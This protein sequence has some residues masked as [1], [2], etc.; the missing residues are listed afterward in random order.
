[1]NRIMKPA[2]VKA[3][4]FPKP[5]SNGEFPIFLRIYKNR[6]SSYVS[7]GY[8]IPA[9]AWNEEEDEVWESMPSLTAKMKAT[10]G[11]EEQ[12]AFKEMQK[13]IILLPNAKKINSDI[14]AKV[15]ELEAI[16]NR[17]L[18]N[19]EDITSSI[20][21]DKADRK[22]LAELSRKD[23][24]SYI[25]EVI[26]KKFAGKQIRT[27]EKYEVLK[28]K[29]KA[30]RKDKPLPIEELTTSFLKGFQAYLKEEGSH[31]NYIHVNLKALRTIIQ[32]EAIK[33]DKILSPEKNPFIWFSMPK[34]LPTIKEKL[35]IDEIKK[36]EDLKLKEDDPLFHVRNAFIFSLY[37]AGIRIGDLM[38]LRWG[39]IKED[40]R[41]EYYMGKTGR[42][43]SIKLLPQALTILKHYEGGNNEETDYIFPFLKNDAPYSK[44]VTIEDFQ[45]ASP[46][47]L[48]E[49]YHNIESQIVRYNAFLKSIA[50]RA[51][52]K[53]NL[54]SHIARHSF[55]DLARKK[56]S[57]YDIQKM[58]GHSSVKVTESYLK[59]LDLDAMDKAME[60]VFK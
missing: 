12:K 13:S 34:V 3:F 14:R 23:F 60:E 40:G 4:L 56:V 27:S 53:K 17:M 25:D 58:L 48:A 33:E 19:G 41:L 21:K 24:I 26:R 8:S 11:K 6:K 38:Q 46:Q 37:N 47:Q 16:Q 35:D 59:S 22:D 29:I 2:K 10:L 1:M 44:L 36:I 51:K 39:N 20:I 15:G 55:A 31:Q 9:G 43:R 32:K 49:L 57:V 52:I 7:S 28:K 54:T 50:F 18:A 5:Y 30:Y 45:K 42:E